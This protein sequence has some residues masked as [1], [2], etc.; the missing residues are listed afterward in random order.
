[1]DVKQHLKKHK[2]FLKNLYKCQTKYQRKRIIFSASE[3][4]LNL[5][6]KVL[7]LIAR[8]EIPIREIYFNDIKRSKRIPALNKLTD[9]KFYHDLVKGPI[10]DKK[11]YLN[12]IPVYRQLLHNLFDLP[13]I[14]CNCNKTK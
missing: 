5:L 7:Q 4:E 8:G 3:L 6:I 10:E 13:K 12:N 1:M 2:H 11:T 14:I 9:K